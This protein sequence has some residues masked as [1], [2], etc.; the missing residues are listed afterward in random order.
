MTMLGSDKIDVGYAHREAINGYNF[1]VIKDHDNT[2]IH[3]LKMADWYKVSRGGKNPFQ[4]VDIHGNRFYN[5]SDSQSRISGGLGFVMNGYVNIAC[6]NVRNQAVIYNL[7][8][9]GLQTGN[10]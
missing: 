8:T 10:V 3:A 2:K 9:S 7:P 6:R 5:L 1:T 4:P